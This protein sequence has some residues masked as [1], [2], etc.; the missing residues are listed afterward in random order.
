MLPLEGLRHS[1]H[2]RRSPRS[3]K[4][5]PVW[6]VHLYPAFPTLLSHLILF[7]DFFST[8]FSSGGKKIF[9]HNTEANAIISIS[10]WI[11]FFLACGI[12]PDWGSNLCPL[13]LEYRVLNHQGSPENFFF[14]KKKLKIA[15]QLQKSYVTLTVNILTKGMSACQML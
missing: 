8:Q 11:F 2:L 14:I 6:T 4:S 1:Y 15:T 12:F 3:L 7:P 5:F 9:Y 13:H 10:V